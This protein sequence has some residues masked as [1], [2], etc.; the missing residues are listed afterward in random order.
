LTL[1]GVALMHKASK[2]S[3]YRH[4]RVRE[5][6]LE[7]KNHLQWVQRVAKVEYV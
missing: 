4:P 2:L 1:T 3:Q 7:V 6:R 5:L